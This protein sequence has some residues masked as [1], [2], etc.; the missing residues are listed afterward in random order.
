MSAFM[1]FHKIY[2]GS[3]S[4]FPKLQEDDFYAMVDRQQQLTQSIHPSAANPEGLR[5]LLRSLQEF[6]HN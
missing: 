6:P 4:V 5:L 3:Q 1:L 2:L